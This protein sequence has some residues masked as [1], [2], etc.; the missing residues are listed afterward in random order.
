MPAQ[1]HPARHQ[2]DKHQKAEQSS[3]Q[4]DSLNRQAEQGERFRFDPADQ[5][6]GRDK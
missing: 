5:I 6:Q 2:Q 3:H 4:G 1:A